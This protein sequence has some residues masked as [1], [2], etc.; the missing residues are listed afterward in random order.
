MYKCLAEDRINYFVLFN[1]IKNRLIYEAY[2]E[3]IQ[4]I[5]SG[6]TIINDNHYYEL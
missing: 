4:L 5:I 2:S 1:K 3:L 6:T